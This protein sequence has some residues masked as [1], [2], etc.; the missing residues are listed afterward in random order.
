LYEIQEYTLSR[1][2]IPMH[3]KKHC[4]KTITLL[5]L[6]IITESTAA[7]LTYPIVGSGV[8][9]FYSN[10]SV[11]TE[12]IAGDEFYGQDAH[13][14]GNLP[15]YT[16]NG[17]GTITDNVTGLMWEQN[18][19]EKIAWNETFNKA[20]TLSLGGHNDW[21]VPSLKELYSLI[22]FTGSVKGA[23]AIE[24]FIDT[25]YFDQLLGDTDADER[26][27]DA[28]T[29]GTTKYVGLTMNGDSTIFGVNFIDGR[30]KGYPQYNPQSK[31]PNRMYTRMVRG[32]SSYGVNDFVDN[33]DG[34]IT[35]LAT[36]LMWQQSD[37]G[38]T[39]DW[40]EALDYCENLEVAGH[41]DW[42]LPTVKELQ[43]LV[44]YSRSPQTTSSPAIDPLFSC[45]EISDPEGVSN[46]GFYWS[47]TTH[48]DGAVPE[49]G[50]C[51]VAFGE[52]LGEMNGNLM[53]VH[54][55]GAQRSDPKSGN[56]SA[57]PQYWGPQGDV[58]YVYNFVRAVR[59]VTVEDET[60]LSTSTK[61]A[62]SSLSVRQISGELSVQMALP[63]S[64]SLS[65][66]LFSINGREIARE[67]NQIFTAGTSSAKLTLGNNL[68]A[69]IYFLQVTGASLVQTQQ[70]VL[71]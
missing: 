18:M 71:R 13:Y 8:T 35:D 2:N 30:I 26:E 49:E 67:E 69:G 61:M 9:D 57:Y 53:D 58:R 27:I 66:S 63:Y 70:V 36:G 23:G 44:D 21:R 15:S 56:A 1:K 33:E 38:T 54:G 24:L 43:S 6:I 12:P 7:E 55:A 62:Q 65:I 3:I 47:G 64:E 20:D 31:E 40:S 68:S 60:L 11:I 46:W 34:T 17:D 51:Y 32:N 16:D 39:R 28:Q 25:S 5:F 42:H 4:I 50:A 59:T 52:A 48:L 45:T 22:L 41:D 10:S 14:P 19:G 37:D 29:W